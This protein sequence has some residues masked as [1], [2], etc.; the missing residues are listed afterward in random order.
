MK[1]PYESTY[2][3]GCTCWCIHF[4]IHFIPHFLKC[5]LLSINIQIVFT[6]LLLQ[7]H[8]YMC[9]LLQRQQSLSIQQFVQLYMVYISS[10]LLGNDKFF[11]KVTINSHIHQ[12]FVQILASTRYHRASVF[13]FSFYQSARQKMISHKVF[14]SV[15]LFLV[16]KNKQETLFKMHILWPHS[17][18]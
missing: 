6:L 12:E 2:C 10:I 17:R 7:E 8:S 4:H 5:F 14:V 18:K 11:C 13:V 3:F 15:L 9:H 1:V 16:Y